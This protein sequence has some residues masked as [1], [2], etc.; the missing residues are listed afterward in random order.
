MMIVFHLGVDK[1]TTSDQQEALE[2][3]IEKNGDILQQNF[4]DNYQNLTSKFTLLNLV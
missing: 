3:E 4:V 2:E 1:S